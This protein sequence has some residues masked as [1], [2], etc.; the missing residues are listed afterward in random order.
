METKTLNEFYKE[1]YEKFRAVNGSPNFGYLCSS[2]KPIIEEFSRRASLAFNPLNKIAI[3]A[4]IIVLR[5]YLRVIERDKD[6]VAVADAVGSVIETTAIELH[7]E[8]STE[9]RK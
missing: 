5:N 8:T 1:L 2:Y 3:P 7:K 6:A 9:T 4:L